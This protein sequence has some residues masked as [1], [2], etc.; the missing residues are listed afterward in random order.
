MKAKDSRLSQYDV[1][2]VGDQHWKSTSTSNIPA[3]NSSRYV[4]KHK[5]V[6]NASF[7]IEISRVM[8]VLFS[9]YSQS[10]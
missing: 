1:G 9:H 7:C 6:K 4:A 10:H 2:E 5:R 8:T 3:I